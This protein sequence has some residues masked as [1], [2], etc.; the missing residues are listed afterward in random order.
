MTVSVDCQDYQD[1]KRTNRQF[2]KRKLDRINM[3]MEK[4][5]NLEKVSKRKR[6]AVISYGFLT[7]RNMTDELL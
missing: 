2:Y 6:K 4:R 1:D 3:T 7:K 5:E